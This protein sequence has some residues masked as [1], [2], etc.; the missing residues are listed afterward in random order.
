[1]KPIISIETLYFQAQKDE[2][3]TPILKDVTPYLVRSPG[4]NGKTL[5]KVLKVKRSALSNAVQLLTGETL[6]DLMKHWKLLTAMHLLRNTSLP[7]K[8]V[9]KRCGYKTI[10]ALSKFMERMIKC[11][12]YEYRENRTHGNRQTDL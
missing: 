10:N 1:M 5:A 6:N 7:Y 9:A 3:D 8:E 2:V 12:A 11:T 4:I